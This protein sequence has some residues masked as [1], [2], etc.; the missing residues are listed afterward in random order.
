MS[1]TP[2]MWVVIA[3]V[4]QAGLPQVHVPLIGERWEYEVLTKDK[5]IA[6]GGKDLAAGLN[7]LGG[8][9]WELAGIDGSYIFK[10]R[11]EPAGKRGQDVKELIPLIEADVAQLKERVSWSERM[12]RKGYMSQGK[13]E[14]ERLRLTSAE[15]SLQKV[16]GQ[17]ERLPPP[18]LKDTN[19]GAGAGNLPRPR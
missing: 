5:V 9:G 14:A 13:V 11:K 7:L 6:L 3:V 19:D 16:R 10:R 4:G 2:L 8:Q 17:V 15:Y 12:L 18:T 1:W